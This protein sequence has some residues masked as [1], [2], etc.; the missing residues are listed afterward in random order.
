MVNDTIV[1]SG[2]F[3]FKVIEN[4]ENLPAGFNWKETAG[5]IT[6]NN[7]D[8]YVFNRGNH[9]VIVFDRLGNFKSS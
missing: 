3:K 4:W 8:I 5:V 1:G 9:P 6:D 7:D 2:K